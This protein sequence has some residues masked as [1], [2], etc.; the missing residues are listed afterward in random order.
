L[1]PKI[2][3]QNVNK[4]FYSQYYYKLE[5]KITGSGFLRYPD[6]TIEAQADKRKYYNDN[7][8]VNFGGSWRYNRS[9]D[10]TDQDILILNKIKTAQQ[11]YPDLRIRVEEPMLQVYSETEKDLYKFAVDISYNDNQHMVCV[12]QPMTVEHMNLLKQGYT[13]SSKPADFPIKV[14]VREGR[15]SL[16]TKR[17]ILTY[18]QNMPDEVKLTK[19]FVESFSRKYESV[20]NCYFYIKDRSVLTMIALISPSLVRTTEEYHLSP[21]DK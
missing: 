6:L 12:N 16:E 19:N 9:S 20:W 14:H 13:I 4:R 17:H 11:K 5:I 8:T 18:L 21:K 7:R 15:Y 1:N 3:I 10:P 2:R